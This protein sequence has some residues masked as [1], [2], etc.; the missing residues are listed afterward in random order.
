MSV[1]MNVGHS[2]ARSIFMQPTL[3]RARELLQIG[4]GSCHFFSYGF[5]LP[6]IFG[7]ICLQSTLHPLTMKGGFKEGRPPHLSEGASCC[8]DQQPEAV[9]VIRELLGSTKVRELRRLR[10]RHSRLAWRVCGYGEWCEG[11]D[12]LCH[13]R[14][15]GELFSPSRGAAGGFLPL[16]PAPSRHLSLACG[17]AHFIPL[18]KEQQLI[19]LIKS[20]CRISN[21]VV[22]FIL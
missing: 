18:A 1:Q 21:T 12:D 5:L 22:C 10:A 17:F 8:Q 7:E 15:R 13:P 3:E 9:P 4:W 2:L 16:P 14:G 6:P 19:I 20:N 11:S